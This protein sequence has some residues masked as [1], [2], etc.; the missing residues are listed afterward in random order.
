MTPA[1]GR[2]THI[3]APPDHPSRGKT[4][5]C[6]SLWIR[7][8]NRDQ[9]VEPARA[10]CA[11]CRRGRYRKPREMPATSRPQRPLTMR[12]VEILD[13]LR[14]YIADHGFPPTIREI[15]AQFR[16][17]STNGVLDHL[18]ALE[19]KGYVERPVAGSSAKRAYRVKGAEPTPAIATPVARGPIVVPVYDPK[20]LA[21][22][23]RSGELSYAYA[24]APRAASPIPYTVAEKAEGPAGRA[25]PSEEQQRDV[26]SPG[27]PH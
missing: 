11:N 12:Q 1:V 8:Y 16:I 20:T 25:E 22:A 17:N 7:D 23:V 27:E 10:T 15:G 9:F 24:P 19:R 3:L 18:R 4:S 13:F 26:G 5:V 21:A 6:G 2:P 14:T